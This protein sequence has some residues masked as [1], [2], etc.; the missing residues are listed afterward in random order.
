MSRGFPKGHKHSALTKQKIG[1]ALRGIWIKYTCGLCNK[2]CEE[3]QARFKKKK[4]H[5]CS[6]RCYALYR[7]KCLPKEEQPRFGTGY[8]TEERKIRRTYLFF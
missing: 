2:Q 4:R 1:L 5:F 7:K 3:Q 6:M 8:S